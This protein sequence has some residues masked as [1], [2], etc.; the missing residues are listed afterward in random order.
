MVISRLDFLLDLFSTEQPHGSAGPSSSDVGLG[1][2][3]HLTQQD[4]LPQL[5]D[6]APLYHQTNH[7]AFEHYDTNQLDL[8][9]PILGFGHQPDQSA[10]LTAYPNASDPAA[11]ASFA[12]EFDLSFM[13]HLTAQDNTFWSSFLASPPDMTAG[14]A[15]TQPKRRRPRIMITAT[16]MPSRHASPGPELEQDQDDGA[17]ETSRTWPAVWNPTGEER[18]VELDDGITTQSLVGLDLAEEITVP[19]FTDKVR[20]ALLE[21]LR[22]SQ[23]SDDEYHALYGT[24]SEVPLTH[25]GKSL[26]WSVRPGP[27][28]ELRPAQ[29]SL[30]GFTSNTSTSTSPSCIS[31]HSAHTKHSLSS[32]S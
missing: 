8:T 6:S 14:P 29:T 7:S 24:I 15:S 30:P 25:L 18:K 16:G 2:H 21:T 19:V 1:S 31:L 10:T 9:N 13:S 3:S 5:A 32:C 26:A 11:A 20:M 4:V 22:F 23:L 12:A 27:A 28:A 17:H